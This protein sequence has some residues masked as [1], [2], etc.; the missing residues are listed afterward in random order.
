MSAPPLAAR[1]T[2]HLEAGNR[3]HGRRINDP[4]SQIRRSGGRQQCRPPF[5]VRSV[6]AA[7]RRLRP[8]GDHVRLGLRQGAVDRHCE[9]RQRFSG[10][11]MTGK[12]FAWVATALMLLA[13]AVPSA[14]SAAT[15]AELAAAKR[16][17]EGIYAKL[18]GDFDYRSV[19]YAPALKALIA[20]DDACAEAGG[21][22]CVIDT[23]P[24]C[25][26]RIPAA[27]TSSSAARW[28]RGATRRARDRADAQFRRHALFG[29]SGADQGPMVRQRY[30][31]ADHAQLCREAAQ[32]A[33][34]RR[35]KQARRV[36]F[37]LPESRHPSQTARWRRAPCST[38]HRRAAPAARQ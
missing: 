22:I 25:D 6:R 2:D 9:A 19:R 4:E 11:S 38:A 28:R 10:G 31:H 37:P 36:S 7:C 17:V 1:Q 5:C 30:R 34:I 14:A 27:I 24:F 15:P 33:E 23:V 21:G 26:C 16:Y 35:L 32:G 12:T 20:R 29:R 13:P 18:P 8:R 3:F